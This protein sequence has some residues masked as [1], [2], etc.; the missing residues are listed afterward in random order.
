MP[1]RPADAADPTVP[2]FRGLVIAHVAI[3]TAVAAFTQ[4]SLPLDA[5]EMVAWGN[6]WELGYHKHPPLPCWV[7]EAL[8]ATFRAAWPL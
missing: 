8:W 1:P 7:G 3:F 6:R 2:L 5:A 4:P